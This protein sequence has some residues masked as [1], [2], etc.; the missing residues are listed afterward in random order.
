MTLTK[1]DIAERLFQ[2]VGITKRDAN[3]MIELFYQLHFI[4][5]GSLLFQCDCSRYFK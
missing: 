4:E 3:E 1:A 2:E 5:R